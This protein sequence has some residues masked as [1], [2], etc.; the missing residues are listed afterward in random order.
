MMRVCKKYIIHIEYDEQHTTP[1]LRKKRAF[2]TNIVSHDY[3]AL[4]IALGVRD[5]KITTYQDFE[6]AYWE[7]ARTIRRTLERWEGFEGPEKYT[8]IVITL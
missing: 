3:Q 6:G 5:I 1:E 7:H 4:Y 2:K 8:M